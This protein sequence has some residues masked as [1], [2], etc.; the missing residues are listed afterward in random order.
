MDILGADDMKWTMRVMAKYAL[1]KLQSQMVD[2]YNIKLDKG[3]SFIDYVHDDLRMC[4][5]QGI[6]KIYKKLLT[7]GEAMP[8]QHHSSIITD[9]GAFLLWVAFKDTAYRD[10]LFWMMDEL[11][12]DKELKND[13]KLF[14]K[15]PKDWYCPQ[16]IASKEET[17][18]LQDEGKLQEFGLSPAE[19]RFVPMLQLDEIDKELKKQLDKERIR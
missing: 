17:A 19:R 13:I 1:K 15:Q 16:W 2:K 10:P 18:R 3:K 12:G 6:R 5:N 11:L 4:P 8:T 7:A 14:V 9:M